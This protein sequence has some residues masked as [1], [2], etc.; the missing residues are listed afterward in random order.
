[1]VLRKLRTER[2]TYI[3]LLKFLNKLASTNKT[4]DTELEIAFTF[5]YKC[6]KRPLVVYR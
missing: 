1:M 4:K 5:T 2:P 3:D 6:E